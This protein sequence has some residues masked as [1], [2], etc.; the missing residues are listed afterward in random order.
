MLFLRPVRTD[1]LDALYALSLSTGG[2]LT[3]LPPSEEVLAKRIAHAMASFAADVDEPGDEYYLFAAEDSATGDVV[4]TSGIFAAVGLVQPF[5][6]YRLLHLT[7]QSHAPEM[8]VDTKL[9]Q[10]V[11]DYAGATEIGTLFLHP[12]HRRGTN[13]A[14]LSKARYL[15]MA[16]FPKRF[17]D[18]VM[19]E[20]RG[21]VDENGR[22]PF[23]E[24]I[25][26]HF[27]GMD[28]AEADRLSGMG[29]S[30]FIADLMPKFPIY[31][32]LL[33]PEAQ[34]I[35]GRPHEAARGAV[36]LLTEEGFRFGGAVDIFDA[37]PCFEAP[38]K[39]I[40]SVRATRR[41]KVFDIADLAGIESGDVRMVAANRLPDFRVVRS[42]IA[43][44]GA[45]GVVL[46]RAAAEI[47]GVTVGDRVLT[48]PLRR[49]RTQA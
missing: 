16:G 32:T 39:E 23:W 34:A 29:N 2:G 31:T 9:L 45:R 38:R 17:A 33:P 48:A 1:D 8:K 46:D 14:L 28:F 10:L 49:K 35:I 37:G 26:R 18:T 21:W 42:A 30:Q 7:Q 44:R 25:G 19:A 20:I 47:L 22:S 15:M 4:G 5:Y 36:R 41:R 43:D 27:F 3:T 6:S 12:D 13:G 40:H 24:A 11:N